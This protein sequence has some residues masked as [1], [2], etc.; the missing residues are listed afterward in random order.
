MK[1]QRYGEWIPASK[2]IPGSPDKVL[3]AYTPANGRTG[4]LSIG[5]DRYIVTEWRT[6]WQGK[7]TRVKYWMPLPNQPKQ[8][9]GK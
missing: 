3:V 1:S 5:L 2:E 8:V 9:R 4:K 6:G 7:G